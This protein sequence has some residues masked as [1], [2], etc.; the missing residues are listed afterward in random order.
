MC[1]IVFIKKMCLWPNLPHPPIKQNP[2]IYTLIISNVF[3]D[4]CILK[5]THT[6]TNLFKN[7]GR[8]L[9]YY[10]KKQHQ[11]GL[12]KLT[13]YCIESETSQNVTIL[14]D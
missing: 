9:D 11:T 13:V 7:K 4:L 3:K 8:Q 1:Q 12:L 14:Y 10:L 6:P 5:N 2:S